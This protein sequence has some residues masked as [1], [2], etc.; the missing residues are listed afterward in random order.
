MS[1]K[2]QKDEIFAFRP[3]VWITG[4]SRGI[5][6]EIAMQFASIGCKVA[7]S[8]RSEKELLKVEKEI[9]QLGGIAQSFP[10][11]VIDTKSIVRTYNKIHHNFGDVDVLINNAGV[12]A[13]KT[14]ESTTEKVFDTIINVNL[15]AMFICIKSVLPSMKKKNSGFIFNILSVA[16]KKAF[17]KSG[18]Y[19]ASKAGG[20][21]LAEVLREEVREHHIRV[22]N[23]F[24]G[25]TATAMWN[26]KSKEKYSH[27]MMSP[28]SVAESVLQAYRSPSDLVCEEII[29]RP[30]LGDV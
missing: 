10:C 1:Q 17:V 7:L 2:S 16:A 9:L 28:R 20:M 25:A 14:I 21:M 4:A 6:K 15:R 22:I 26:E 24:P 11:D 3:V 5:G 30:P 8:S 29:L 18:V 23:V 27:R 13:F 19:A 12:T